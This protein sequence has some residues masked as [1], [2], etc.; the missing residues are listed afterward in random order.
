MEAEAEYKREEAMKNMNIN[1]MTSVPVF[2]TFEKKVEMCHW[3]KS[4]NKKLRVPF[5]DN[6][7]HGP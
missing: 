6:K 4:S 3:A 2:L 1:Q 7:C 5:K